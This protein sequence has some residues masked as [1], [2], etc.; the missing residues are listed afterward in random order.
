MSLFFVKR[1]P[2]LAPGTTG[3][4]S[5]AAPRGPR[6]SDRRPGRAPILRIVFAA[7]AVHVYA[8]AGA[9][10]LAVF[11]DGRILPV[12]GARVI[13]DARIHLDLPGGGAIEIPLTRLDRVIEDVIEAKPEP[14]KRP[15]CHVGFVDEAM[16]AGTPFAAEIREASRQANLHPRLVAGVVA[17]ESAF[18]PMAVSRVGALGLMQLMPSVWMAERAANPFDPASNLRSGC[19]HLRALL[20]RFNDATLA[21]AA[22]NAG[23]AV[24]DRSGGM[25]PYR[26]TREFVRAVLSRFCPSS[27]STSGAGSGL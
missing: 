10:Y 14:I 15:A 1:C 25:P 18:K 20:D 2:W 26:E 22:Y 7:L 12:A 23:A 6:T 19:R 3:A 11:V 8:L 13:G 21:L 9:Q 5:G 4:S 16:P 27:P 17:A 24:V